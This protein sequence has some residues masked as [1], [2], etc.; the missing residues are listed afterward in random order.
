[1]DQEFDPS[2]IERT[3]HRIT[4]VYQGRIPDRVPGYTVE[5]YPMPAPGLM[6]FDPQ[7]QLDYQLSKLH[8]QQEDDLDVM[9]GVYP[10]LNATFFPSLFGAEIDVPENDGSRN[11]PYYDR[12]RLHRR[13][14]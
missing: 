14:R 7:L 8:L 12:I 4:S 6:Y 3:A 5:D 11:K 1:M 13:R 2:W 9:P 10:L